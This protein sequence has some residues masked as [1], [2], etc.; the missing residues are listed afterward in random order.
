[1]LKSA[2]FEN[3]NQIQL[4]NEPHPFISKM[5]IMDALVSGNVTILTFGKPKLEDVP[6]STF[7]LNLLML[8]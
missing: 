4:R 3:E 5:V 1:M 6:P 7:D 2:T 8:M